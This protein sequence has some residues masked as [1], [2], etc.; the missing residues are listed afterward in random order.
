MDQNID[1]ESSLT[2]TNFESSVEFVTTTLS[3]IPFVGGLISATANHYIQK[4][5]SERQLK[6]FISLADDLMSVGDKLN[7]EFMDSE[8]FKDL[9][10]DVFYKATEDVR[11]K[12]L[13]AYRAIFVNTVLS[14]SPNIDESFEMLDLIYHWQERHIVILKILAN[15]SKANEEMDNVVSNNLSASIGHILE[16]LLP[17]WTSGQIKRTWVDFY[18][19]GIHRT[20][21]LTVSLVG[22][23]IHPLENR[24]TDYGDEIVKYL[25]NP[26]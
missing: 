25:E 17:N 4:R 12:K 10:E 20:K 9:V 3:S 11:K 5:Q 13:D 23:G 1:V 24:L 6:L 26:L 7:R 2:S 15:P 21:E 16:K 18:N 19:K 8:D 22:S 14:E